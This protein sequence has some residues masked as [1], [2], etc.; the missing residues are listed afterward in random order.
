M[1]NYLEKNE[2]TEVSII[3]FSVRSQ[4]LDVKEWLPW[5][6][7]DSLCIA[8]RVSEETM[9]HFMY[10]KSYENKPCINWKEVY[11][12]DLDNVF[13]IGKLILK[14]HIERKKLLEI[15]A[16]Q[17]PDPDSTAPGDS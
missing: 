10:C 4:T 12:D 13:T 7:S 15:K 11:N 3:I 1:S 2:N 17:A 14:R 16:G 5:N 6:Y 9:D 8:C